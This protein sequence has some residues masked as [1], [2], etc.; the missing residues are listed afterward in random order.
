MCEYLHANIIASANA[1]LPARTVGNNHTPK[2][3]KDLET[4]IQHYHF[5]NRVTHSIKLLR[6]YPHT[7]SS[8]HD[9]KWSGYLTRLNNIFN[10]YKSTFPAVPI[11]PL[12]LLSCRTDNFNNLFQTL[13]H[14]SKLLRG[15]HL[16]K[17]KEFQDSS[18]K[19]HLESR[20]QN[21]DTDISS[22]I[23]SALSRSRHRI[24][25]N[26]VFIDHPTTLQLL[27]DPRDVSVAVTNHFQHAVPINS[28][29]SPPSLEKW[30]STVSS[31]PNGKAPGPSMITYEMLKHLG[32]TTNSLLLTLIRKCGNFAGLP[33][34]TCR[35]PIITLESIIHDAN[36]NKSSLWILSQDI[37]KTFDSVNLTILKFA[38]E[39]IRL[40]AS[41]ITLILSIFMNRSNWV[42]T[43]YGETSSYRVRI[44]IDQ[45]EVIFPLL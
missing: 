27:T 2:L 38:L 44:G 8:S 41:A 4:L 31:M 42:F 11:L 13:S 16:L 33:G 12:S 26:R 34:G 23:N 40:P 36:H 6:K 21:F 7:F 25:L 1:V 30:L 24:V 3:P 20:D 35:D 29:L 14:A 5:L 32:P 37:S 43:A 18:I 45:G 15:L 22:F 17:E 10:L 19:A 28:L 39:R 9:Q